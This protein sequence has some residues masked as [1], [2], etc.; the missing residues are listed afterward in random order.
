[1]ALKYSCIALRFI[2]C[3]PESKDKK[4]NNDPAAKTVP[5]PHVNQVL[6]VMS[7][8]KRKNGDEH[9][10]TYYTCSNSPGLPITDA[11]LEGYTQLDKLAV[12]PEVLTCVTEMLRQREWEGWEYKCALKSG[13]FA[14]KKN[15]ESSQFAAERVVFKR[16]ARN[17]IGSLKGE[18]PRN[19]RGDVDQIQRITNFMSPRGE[20]GEKG[21]LQEE[22]KKEEWVAGPPEYKPTS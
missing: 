21:R 15:M 9:L 16:K 11:D 5:A 1:M 20:T 4:D 6:L 14:S 12:K 2:L 3:G 22:D 17:S 19:P 8:W 13:S 7:G 18:G 10:S